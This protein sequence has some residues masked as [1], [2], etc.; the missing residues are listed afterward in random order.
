MR[1]KEKFEKGAARTPG[2]PRFEL[3]PPEGQTRTAIRYTIGS[4]KFGEGNWKKGGKAFIKSAIGHL[5]SHL[6]KFKASGNKGDDNLGAIGWSV[7]SLCWFEENKPKEFA[8]ALK[9]LRG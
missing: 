5:E 8:Q 7:A 3:I 9:E 1:K 2:T 4:V 6:Q